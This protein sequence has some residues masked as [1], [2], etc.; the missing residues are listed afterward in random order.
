MQYVALDEEFLETDFHGFGLDWK[1][2][3]D[4][5][6]RPLKVHSNVFHNLGNVY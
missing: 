4:F 2:A 1:W 5:V 6:L 3:A